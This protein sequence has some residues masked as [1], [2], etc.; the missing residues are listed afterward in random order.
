M[1]LHF[2]VVDPRV[3][4]NLGEFY[5]AGVMYLNCHG[6]QGKISTIKA[7]KSPCHV[8]V[9]HILF[10]HDEPIEGTIKNLKVYQPFG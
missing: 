6:V 4:C 9:E 7:I 8:E 2:Q 3:H 5:G 1:S 10:F